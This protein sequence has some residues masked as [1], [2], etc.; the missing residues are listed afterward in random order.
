MNLAAF[1][2]ATP[3]VAVIVLLGIF[4]FKRARWRRRRRA[5]PE[6][7]GFYP[8]ASS[9]GN[10]FHSL[11]TFTRPTVAYVLEEKYDEDMEDDGDGG[12]DDPTR[13]LNRQ[14]KR[15]R[16]GERVDTLTVRLRQH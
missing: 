9:L 8:S 10:A 5:K 15:I 13:Q 7:A 16:R 2:V 1:F 11:Q 3:Y 12:P 14:L 4:Y 6:Y